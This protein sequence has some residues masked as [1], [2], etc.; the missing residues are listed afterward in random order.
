MRPDRSDG[1]WSADVDGAIQFRS[2]SRP[3]LGDV[4]TVVEA[5]AADLARLIPARA[6]E[7]QEPADA[8]Q[9]LELASLMNR[10]AFGPSGS[11]DQSA[12]TSW[13]AGM[14]STGS[15]ERRGELDVPGREP[16]TQAPILGR[17]PRV[18]HVP[19]TSWSEFSQVHSAHPS[20]DCRSDSNAR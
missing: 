5:V 9:V 17:I 16:R 11:P 14:Y 13:R 7:E 18:E 3:T 20:Y 19:R 4:S 1:T 6:A 15:H 10:S 2:T 8:Q 12:R